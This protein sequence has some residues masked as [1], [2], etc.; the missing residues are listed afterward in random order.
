MRRSL[1]AVNDVHQAPSASLPYN[2]QALGTNGVC[3]RSS[4]PLALPISGKGEGTEWNK[5]LDLPAF[6][7]PSRLHPQRR[8]HKN[9]KLIFVETDVK[10]WP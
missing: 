7:T 5:T 2:D 6:H 1:T 3:L 9:G 4:N 10:V 8:W